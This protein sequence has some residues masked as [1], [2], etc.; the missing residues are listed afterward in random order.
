MKV[1]KF[2]NNVMQAELSPIRT[3][4]KEWEQRIPDVTRYPE[5]GKQGCT[6]KSR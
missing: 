1:K 6:S 2:L 5:R 4:R 3:R